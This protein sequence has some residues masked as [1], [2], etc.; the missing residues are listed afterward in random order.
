MEIIRQA[1]EGLLIDISPES[2]IKEM[3]ALEDLKRK[4]LIKVKWA[5]ATGDAQPD[6]PPDS[7][8]QHASQ[9]AGEPSSMPK[10]ETAAPPQKP[11]KI[12][13]ILSRLAVYTKAYHFDHFAQPGTPLS[14][15]V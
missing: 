13:P 6:E 8:E 3:P 10:E 11:F 14:S 2:G 12:L 15:L 5:P 1:W 9:D 7:V 4:I